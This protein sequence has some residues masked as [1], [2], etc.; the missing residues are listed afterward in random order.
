MLSAT[1]SSRGRGKNGERRA[2]AAV[3]MA[4]GHGFLPY[5]FF[6]GFLLLTVPQL[7]A[8][9]GVP[10]P[11]IA[12][13]TGTAMIP[14]F[15]A[16]LIAPILDVWLSRRSWA[17]VTAVLTALALGSAQFLLDDLPALTAMLFLGF[18]AATLYYGAV[19]GWLGDIIAPEQDASLGAWLTVSNMAGFGLMASVAISLIRA[20]PVSVS[21][22]LLGSSP[23]L[24]LGLL[25]IPAKPPSSRLARESFSGFFRELGVVLRRPSVWRLMLIFVLPAASFALT[26]TLGG[27]GG[28]YGASELEV[29]VFGGLGGTFAACI[30]SLAVIPLARRMAPFRLY[31]MIGG[32]GAL[33]TL[34]LIFA[35][36]V[37]PMFAVAIS[38]QN[39]FQ[40]A[41]FS[42][43][44][45]VQFNE[46]GKGNPFAATQFSLFTAATTFPITY[47]QFIDGNAYGRGGLGAMFATDALLGLAAVG[48]IALLLFV[49]RARARPA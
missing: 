18:A 5:G 15:T 48:L 37:A 25:L 2:A 40:A 27:L 12:S 9:R 11:L 32:A 7:L 10:E 4:D 42:T 13:V 45:A 29:S 31:L 30:G 47:M 19:G 35:P 34:G 46:I 21:A 3:D 44:N 6:G 33:F 26:N 24:A 8:A 14:S 17:L 28:V 16:F 41:A 1:D 20:V 39:L 49:W 43:E 23:L 36:H 38:G 22:L